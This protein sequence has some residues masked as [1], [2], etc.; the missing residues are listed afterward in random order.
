MSATQK[1]YASLTNQEVHEIVTDIDNKIL[2]V[3]RS[4]ELFKD[5]DEKNYSMYLAKEVAYM[6]CRNLILSKL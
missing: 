4:R 6:E 3:S 2:S 1:P 5:M